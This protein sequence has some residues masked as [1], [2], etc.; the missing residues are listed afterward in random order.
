MAVTHLSVRV[1]WHDSV[2]NGTICND[3]AANCHCVDYDNILQGRN[4]LY[5]LTV[6]GQQWDSPEVTEL[7][8]CAK[9][10][11]GFLSPREWT[12][13]HT[14]PYT[15]IEACARTHGHL[16]D[17]HFRVDPYTAYA[18][19]FQWLNRANVN[20]Y[21]Q[22]RV[23]EPLPVEE[24][25]PKDFFSKWVFSPALQEA[26]LKGFFAP[27]QAG[28]SLAIFYTKGAH[29][30][31]DDLPRLV[32]GVGDVTNVGPQRHYKA[33]QG[34]RP[35]PVWERAIG[36]S[37][38][39]DQTGGFLLPYH[40]YLASTGDPA[41][42][43][44]RREL[45]REL[46]VVPERDRMLE[47][48][49]RTEH[50]SDDSAIAILTQCLTSVT[51]IRKDG[52]A[53]GNWNGVEAWLNDRL[54]RVWKLR[55]PFPGIGVVLEAMG[56]R[57]GTA[58]CFGLSSRDPAFATK[59]WET[60]SAVIMGK[61][62]PPH[63]R[64]ALELDA[65]RSTWQQVVNTPERL[66]WARCLSGFA[67][68]SEQATRWWDRD[69]RAKL[70]HRGLEDSQLLANPYLLAELDPGGGGADA[71]VS[72]TTVD[73]GLTS[74]LAGK[75]AVAAGDRRRRRAALVSVLRYATVQGDT[76]LGI[77]EARSRV[78]EIP[79]KSVNVPEEWFAAEAEFIAQ[80][81]NRVDSEPPAVQLRE[82]TEVAGL[83]Q[84]KLSARATRSLPAIDA[85][86]RDLLV[87]TVR[88][89]LDN[90]KAF[91]PND[92]RVAAALDEQAAALVTVV[93]RK[94][95][96][97]VGRAGTGKT[98]VL[99]ALSRCEQ[100]KGRVL[101][102]APTGK[103][104]VRL[105]SRVVSGSEVMTV[106]QFLHRNKR[107]DGR[108]QRPLIDE[109]C[110]DGHET[111]VIDECSMLTEDD[112]GAVLATLLGA[113]KRLILVGDPA[114]LPPI[115][116]GR[117]FADLIAHLDPLVELKDVDSD[118]V[119]QRRQAIARLR[120]EVRTVQGSRSDTLRLANWF[121]GDKPSPDAESIFTELCQST[122]LNDLDVRF[123]A[124]P[125]EL[126]TEV[127]LALQ[128]HL[129][130]RGPEDLEGFNESFAMQRFKGGWTTGDPAGAELWQ[131]LSPIRGEVCGCDDINRWVKGNWRGKSLSWARQY[132]A[133]FGE[134]EITKHDK[135]IL[136]RNGE[137]SGYD[138]QTG[139]FEAY[140]ANGEVG[141]A[142]Y[143]KRVTT[144]TGKGHVMNIA[145]AGRPESQTFGFWKNEFGGEAGAG[146]IEL[147]Y[148]LTVHKAQG[149][150][151]GV[152]IVIL[153]KGRMAY[154][155][156]VYTALTRSRR[157]LVLLLQG[158]DVSELLNLRKPSSSDTNRRNTN[159]F[160]VAVRDGLIR[161]F[162]RHL[163]H[164]AEDGT[165]LS[166]KS[167]LFIY[168]QCLAAGLRPRYEQRY[169]GNDGRWKLPDFTFEDEAGDP[170][171]WEHLG[172]LNDQEYAAG[173][174]RKKRWYGEQGFINDQTLFWTDEVG[175]LD[176][177][178][179]G[180]VIGRIRDLLG[181]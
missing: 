69:K 153:P 87:E 98:T 140:L 151:F 160:E 37:L 57:L 90:P 70:V 45:A 56:F 47:F 34:S 167:E 165:L 108:R 86:W 23:L 104:R 164:R 133:T 172:L 112:L 107:Y 142:K 103:A 79:T 20:D 176:A 157:R 64:F 76:L 55:G 65:F 30:V 158:S 66:D 61:A 115:G 120:Q 109:A 169:D 67:L 122:P 24:E 48:S 83:L 89:T 9:E 162:A 125:E 15:K 156:L 22:P 35:Q 25:F 161:P 168:S 128:R 118:H 73:R 13:K 175:G 149:S 41:E 39:A 135:V 33:P 171:L 38:R 119:E 141:L 99:G 51:R 32:V 166:S 102:L 100:F 139:E 94:L 148:A 85:N 17:T 131:I 46:A 60:V 173:W 3:P 121:T 50:V 170:I 68:S 40:T 134:Q 97:L 136:L 58:F 155:E 178:K 146:I 111:I 59:A 21:V 91:N 5:E 19:P 26:I 84:R 78:E 177:S 143:D 18:V 152:V 52:I 130:V 74:D 88:A 53:E 42:D 174:E 81:I 31:G 147:A 72:F 12:S 63:D 82:R 101:F 181:K 124:T 49:Y 43:K 179:V 117:P 113:V 154:R 180:A 62:A 132:H 92:A 80:R 7:P 36:H 1:P 116:A 71:P 8:P 150:E 106:A 4:T 44:R 54:A 114:Q 145:F 138:H 16:G 123:W 10:A 27:V 75:S 6:K 137:R 159:V 127:L 129:G 29:P 2:W 77:P 28:H 163:V 144:K 105:E 93:S 11:G 96:C 126:H 110:Y 95:T 14:H